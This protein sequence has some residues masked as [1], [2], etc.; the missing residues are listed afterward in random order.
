[1]TEPTRP[2]KPPT[3]NAAQEATG[4]GA[5]PGLATSG[6][7]TYLH[8]PAA[9]VREAAAFYRDVFGWTIHDPDGDRPSFDTPNGRLS[10]A[11][12]SRDLVPHEPGLLP[13]IYVDDVDATVAAITSRGGAMVTEP[14]PEGVLTV[15]TFRDPAGNQLGLWHDTTR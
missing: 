4:Q 8:I 13:Y 10:G 11:F 14:Y 12:M 7:L 3:T 6:A 5:D 2:A 15:A 9:E 1:M